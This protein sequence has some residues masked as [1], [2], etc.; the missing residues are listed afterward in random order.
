VKTYGKVPL[1]SLS[2]EICLRGTCHHSGGVSSSS[3]YNAFFLNLF[4]WVLLL[5]KVNIQEPLLF[6]PDK[7]EKQKEVGD[8]K[9]CFFTSLPSISNHSSLV[10]VASCRDAPVR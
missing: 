10:I 6:S 4:K 3:I 1:L 9:F 7:R 5:F 8:S 2:T